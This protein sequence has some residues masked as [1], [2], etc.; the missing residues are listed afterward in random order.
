M[1]CESKVTSVSWIPSEAIDRMTVRAPFDLGLFHYDEPPPSELEDLEALRR[2][3]RFRFANELRAWIEVESNKVVAAGYLGGGVMGSTT[4]RLARRQVVFPAVGLPDVPKAPE[5]LG[6]EVR[7]VQT[8][9]GRVGLP[10][11]RRVSYPP[12]VQWVPPTVW[13]TLAL[14]IRADGSSDYQMLGASPFPR[15]WLF[16]TSDK[17]VAKAG[18]TDFELWWR[19]SFGAHTPW[20]DEDSPALLVPAETE[21]ERQ[22]SDLIM[23]AGAKPTLQLVEAGDFLVRQGEVE[24]K[25]FLILNGI[26]GVD[27]DGRQIAQVGPGAI[28]GERALLEGGRR[29]ATLRALTRCKVASAEDAQIDPAKLHALSQAH[30]REE[31]VDTNGADSRGA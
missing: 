24:T 18:L 13:T 1:R 6:N 25:V 30:R 4:L 29:T 3:D 15:H 8:A 20:G 10:A 7:F 21:L 12:F 11:P 9:G 28:V 5:I 26:L 17:L 23:H 27:V 22:L 2:A 16:D 14:T 19:R 31:R